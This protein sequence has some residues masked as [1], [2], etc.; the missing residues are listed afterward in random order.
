MTDEDRE[1]LED[2]RIRLP[3]DRL[4]LEQECCDQAIIYDEIGSWVAEVRSRAKIA[5]EHVSFVEAELSLKVRKNPADFGL[6]VDKKPTEGTIVSTV[7]THEDYQEAVSDHI[8]ADRFANE[9]AVLLAAAEQRKSGL[10]DL[11][12]LYVNNYYS[13]DDT[14]FDTSGWEQGEKAIQDARRRR[15]VS[16]EDTKEDHRE[17]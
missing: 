11:V 16:S 13:K 6:P 4:E 8:E 15:Q 2:F 7:T 17:E 3:L 5:K 12:R 9:A 1:I 14:G 10:R